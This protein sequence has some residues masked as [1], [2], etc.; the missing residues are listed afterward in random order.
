MN[1]N[2]QQQQQSQ[3]GS[4]LTRYRSA[5]SSYFSSL[6]NDVGF[7]A[8]DELDHLFNPRAS[9][10]EPHRIWTSSTTTPPL[11]SQS[12]INNSQF[13]PHPK[14]EPEAQQLQ[15]NDYSS[16]A[17]MIYQSHNSEA[18]NS[19]AMDNLYNG[20]TGSFDPTHGPPM[21]MEGGN[22]SLIRH[23]S[24]P[25]G[26]F[27]NINIENEFGATRGIGSFGGGTNAKTE[28]LFSSG[29][30]FKSQM[31]YSSRIMDPIG[32]NDPGDDHEDYV[33]G[34]SMN[35][36]DDSSILSDNYLNND[37]KRFAN[38]SSSH[39]QNN[40]GG[41]RS[42]TLLSRH[43]SLP[44]S[45]A[46]LSAMEK[47]FQDSVPCKIRAK[48]GFATHPRS[49]AE[50]VRRTKISERMRKLQELVPNMEKQ[51]N[52]SDMLDLAVDYIK[53][54]QRQVNTLSDNRAKCSCSGKQKS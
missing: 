23:R 28:A 50:R 44:Q 37:D 16:A 41:N 5:P 14:H 6:L 52:T 40:E 45:S 13:L 29:S 25:A 19:A 30:K 3:T 51:T 53:D 26:L 2:Q 9:T 12:H 8:S 33:S 35:S 54:L 32:E 24:S 11:Q 15:S 46:E 27:A 22:S 4:G 36:W 21:K 47:L 39:D 48:R 38:S 20:Q 1:N 18:P 49:I 34:F 31:D 7:G 42:R 43:L 10:P 17:H